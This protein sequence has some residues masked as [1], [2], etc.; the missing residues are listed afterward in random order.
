MKKSRRIVLD[1][2]ENSARMPDEIVVARHS[3]EYLRMLNVAISATS[4]LFPRTSYAMK[5][6][7]P[8][9]GFP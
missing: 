1:K 9:V 5:R 7:V 3:R 8:T 4:E 6:H 2:L